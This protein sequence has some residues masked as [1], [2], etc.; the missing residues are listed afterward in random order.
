[1]ASTQPCAAF[2]TSTSDSNPTARMMR[3]RERRAA[4]SRRRSWSVNSDER[5]PRTAV[6]ATA[7]VASLLPARARSFSG[8]ILPRIEVGRIVSSQSTRNSEGKRAGRPIP[9][10]LGGTAG[11][12]G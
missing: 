9:T 6:V 7:L 3:S 5:R 10:G 11:A 12:G 1:M 2:V 4:V 8:I